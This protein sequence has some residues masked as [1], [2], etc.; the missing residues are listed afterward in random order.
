MKKN[1][2][3]KKIMSHLVITLSLTTAASYAAIYN[4]TNSNLS[5]AYG[6][7]HSGNEKELK[8]LHQ[9]F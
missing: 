7:C 4:P 9:Q 2:H 3:F 6:P 8:K 1:H 5:V